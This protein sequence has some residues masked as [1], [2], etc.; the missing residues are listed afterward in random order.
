VSKVRNVIPAQAGIQ[1]FLDQ[2][3]F[4]PSPMGVNFSTFAIVLA[5]DGASETS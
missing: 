5:T 1:G 2:Y 4:R 3:G